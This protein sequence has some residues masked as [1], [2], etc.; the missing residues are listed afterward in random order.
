MK[1]TPALLLAVSLLCG[2]VAAQNDL[3]G[4]DFPNVSP[5]FALAVQA[6]GTAS[7][8]GRINYAED[9][10]VFSFQAG[11]NATLTV[12]S[13]G[14]TDT[15]GVLR[16]QN[17]TGWTTVV[18]EEGGMGN[19]RIS[20]AVEA[21]RYSIQVSGRLTT[22]AGTISGAYGLRVELTP[23]VPP[24]PGDIEVPEVARGGSMAF[25][26]VP[27]NTLVSRS[28]T[29]RNAGA[30]NLQIT[31]VT[32]A[33][34]T[35]GGAGNDPATGQ[36]FMIENGGAR[37]VA[38]GASSTVRV[39]FKPLAAGNFTGV[40]NIVSNDPDENPYGFTVTGSGAAAPPPPPPDEGEIAVRLGD[41]E[42]RS[43]G[44]V[45][46]GQVMVPSTAPVVRELVIS[47]TGE[48]NLQLGAVVIAPLPTV[49]I[50]PPA[51][52]GFFRV[53]TPPAAVL[54]PGRTT[55]VRIGAG[56]NVN[57]APLHYV[58]EATIQNSDADENPYRLL[59]SADVKAPPPPAA[60]EINVLSGEAALTDD[61]TLNFGTTPTGTPVTKTLTIRNSGEGELRI[62]GIVVEWSGPIIAIFPPPPLPFRVEGG[63][64]RVVAPGAATTCRVI[65]P[66]TA[67]GFAA[68]ILRIN[69]SDA[70]ENP[71]SLTLLATSE[72]DPVPP[73]APE[74][75][76]GLGGGAADVPNG[77][78]VD[79]GRT[80][81]TVPVRKTLLISNRGTGPLLVRAGFQPVTRAVNTVLPFR[82][83]S[84]PF[85][86]VAP[87]ATRELPIVFQPVTSGSFQTMLVI[88]NNDSD[89]NP[90]R[91]KLT[92]QGGTDPD[93][94][95]DIGLSLGGAEL[96]TGGLVDFGTAEPGR[97]VT[98]EIKITNSGNG[99]LRLGRISFA[100]GTTTPSGGVNAAGEVILPPVGALPF[101][102]LPPPNNVVPA[103]GFAILRVVYMAPPAGSQTALMSIE[104]NDPDENPWKLVLK[105][106]SSGTVPVPPEIAVSSGGANLP[107]GG[108]LEFGF[109]VLGTPGRR[110]IV[111]A[112]TGG[113]ELR[114]AGFSILPADMFANNDTGLFLPPPALVRVVS[115]PGI[116]P[117]G[118]TG[119]FVLEMIGFTPG[120]ARLF[121]RITNNDPDE[122]P[123]SFGITGRIGNPP[124]I[125][126]AV[127]K[128]AGNTP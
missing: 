32:I 67:P 112:N 18:T 65:F 93:A 47:N 21:G 1:T 127:V 128:P 14:T 105:G 37:T 87:G 95:P 42:V 97:S 53:L 121:A 64:A 55:V 48:T 62:S 43:G 78:T 7:A 60:G 59:L 16:R 13:T 85:S 79:F 58:M 104:S 24:Q 117:A 35:A 54:E 76:I 25:G 30:G 99:D 46:F 2:T 73:T 68:A 38:P 122:N 82:F 124:P 56:G 66:A 74:I 33:G 91:L 20:R 36:P 90:Y 27:L 77:G 28:F 40:V 80:S 41:A 44:T 125:D 115:G 86:T 6:D 113:G 120:E 71:F 72:G 109:V 88:S 70:D 4:D 22:N 23:A 102:A 69:N 50:L 94:V 108:T 61:G 11:A 81:L 84:E 45:D 3:P 39:I 29:L 52:A 26:S 114:I 119:V 5:G 15:K 31:G 51:P 83:A 96:A 98:K 123:Y 89:E 107:I 57:A 126:P 116:I 92:G 111:L 8:N 63:E 75:A 34:V 10:D 103:G 17:S 118:G 12:Y 106:A 9:L 101:R 100:T 19:F 49:S 110:E